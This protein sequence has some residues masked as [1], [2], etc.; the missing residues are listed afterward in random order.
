MKR[1][2]IAGGSGLL[3]VCL[4]RY[5][6]SLSYVV[7]SHGNVFGR[8]CTGDFTDFGVTCEVLKAVHADVIINLIALTNVDLCEKHPHR[9]YLLNVRVIENITRWL[10][11]QINITPLIHISTDQLYNANCS[12]EDDIQIN[13]MYAMTKY[14]GDL[15]ASQADG[16]IL[17]TNFF[18]P[19]EHERRMS[20]SDWLITAFNKQ[21]QI[22]LF[23][24][25]Y[26]SP[27]SIS[28]LVKYIEICIKDYHGGIYN[29]GSNGGMSKAAFAHCLARTMSLDDSQAKDVIFDGSKFMARRPKDMR[30]DLNKF[31]N[32]FQITLPSLIDE[33]ERMKSEI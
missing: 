27:L 1:V 20:F 3:G 18:G 17:R 26:F 10:Q 4:T 15:I 32:K 33:I 16:M 13:N 5:L 8:D 25:I 21:K 14:T 12:K 28:S 19:S 6:E 11:G 30:M 22:S 31:Q 9:A 23:K 2:F 24:D 29:L 7:I